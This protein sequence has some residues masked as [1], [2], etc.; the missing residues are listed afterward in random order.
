M[1]AAT[2]HTPRTGEVVLSLPARLAAGNTYNED[3]ADV[4]AVRGE[5]G[6]ALPY[7]D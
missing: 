5:D 4:V 1:T 3:N 6:Y 7:P 2:T